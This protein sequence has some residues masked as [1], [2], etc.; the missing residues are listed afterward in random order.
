[1]RTRLFGP[2]SLAIALLTVVSLVLAACGPAATPVPPTQAPPPPTS[3][4]VPQGIRLSMAPGA[5]TVL[6]SASVGNGGSVT[7]LVR[8][9]ANQYLMAMINSANPNLSLEI[10]TPGGGL[11][12]PSSAAL[13]SW[14]GNLPVG[15]DYQVSVVSR[16]GQGDFTLNVTIPVRVVFQAGAVSA[17]LDGYVYARGVN[18]YLLRALKDQTMTV[19]ISSPQNNIFLT[20]YGLQD[21]QP[22]I[23][24]VTGQ[25]SYTF[26]LP[27]TQDYVIECVSVSDNP[28]SYQVKFVVQ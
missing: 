5:T 20:I 2:A 23:R 28:E 11:L 4:P 19:T 13:S 21:G 27:A 26:K 14:Q 3:V 6:A 22:Y 18:T 12:V 7:Y 10:R 16:G 25:T 17:S 9:A 15:G 8:A 1:M 24:S